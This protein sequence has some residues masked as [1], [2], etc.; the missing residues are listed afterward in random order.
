MYVDIDCLRV[1]LEIEEVVG[2]MLGGDQLLVAVHHSLVKIR[3]P[4]VSPVD[5][6]ELLGVAFARELRQAYESADFHQ[7]GLG[8]NGDELFVDGFAKQPCYALAQGAGQELIEV[9]I[10]VIKL[11]LHRWVHQGQALELTGY[12]AQLHRV[13]FQEFPAR[14]EIEEQVFDREIAARGAC[15]RGLA[16]EFRG[17]QFE[18]GANL[19]VAAH[20]A[21][22]N[23]RD[24]SY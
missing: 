6:E 9:H 21:Q 2:L 23:L 8:L 19:A 13:F 7:R 24:S 3:V 20:R 18:M 16:D 12:M 17:S 4:H 14:G 22:V 15:F 1:D 10:V 11:K 5:E